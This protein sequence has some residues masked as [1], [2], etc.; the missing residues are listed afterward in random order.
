[1]FFFV[2]VVVRSNK[3][4]LSRS[5]SRCL[6]SPQPPSLPCPLLFL[7]NLFFHYCVPAPPPSSLLHFA[8]RSRPAVL[9]VHIAPF[10]ATQMIF[11]WFED[12]DYH[13]VDVEVKVE[14]LEDDDDKRTATCYV[15]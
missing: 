14:A 6:V 13:K 5:T 9:Y 4:L 11:D 2:V 12:D 15:W 1:M 7:G 3:P 8:T 10:L